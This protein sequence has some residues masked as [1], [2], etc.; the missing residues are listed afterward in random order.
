MGHEALTPDLRQKLQEEMQWMAGERQHCITGIVG[1][2]SGGA[3]GK[4]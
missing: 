4:N 1:D 3:K 2:P